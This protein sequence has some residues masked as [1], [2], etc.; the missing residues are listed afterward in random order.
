MTPADFLAGIP[1]RQLQ[2]RDGI[3][4]AA[5]HYGAELRKLRLSPATEAAAIRDGERAVKQR[6]AA[7]GYS[8]AEAKDCGRIFKVH[9][10]RWLINTPRF[11]AKCR[12]CKLQA[13]LRS[14]PSC[15]PT[16]GVP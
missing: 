3:I 1:R 7:A 6:C 14:S 12:Q 9:C 4:V 16:W 2:T 11:A 13:W 8:D 15:V 5:E 10:L